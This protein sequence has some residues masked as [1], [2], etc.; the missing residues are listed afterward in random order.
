LWVIR[1]IFADEG[2]GFLRSLDGEEIYFHRNSIVGVRFENLE[3]G[4]GVNFTA[5]LGDKGLQASTVQVIQNSP[6]RNEKEQQG[7][8]DVS[9]LGWQRQ[10]K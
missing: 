9:P 2:Y 5:E 1:K 10:K 3:P 8:D 7:G 4:A 6:G